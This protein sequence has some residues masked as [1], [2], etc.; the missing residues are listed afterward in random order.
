MPCCK[1]NPADAYKGHG[2]IS[3][4]DRKCRDVLCLLLF[5]AFSLGGLIIGAIGLKYG[6]PA[7]MLYGTDYEGNVCGMGAMK[8]RRYTAYP[9]GNFDFIMNAGKSP[10]DYSFY[11]ICV[12]S[13]PGDV[14]PVCNNMYYSKL[15]NPV[16]AAAIKVSVRK[17]VRRG[18]GQPGVVTCSVLL[19]VLPNDRHHPSLSLPSHFTSTSSPH[20]SPLVPRRPAFCLPAAATQPATPT[21]T[22]AGSMGWPP[23]LSS[24]AACRS[25]T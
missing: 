10:L 2:F 3:S 20:L 13:C 25:T 18:R 6:E 4:P 22:T 5:T 24:S 7:R 1:R 21:A 9:R 15:A 11:G 16:D 14:T 12:A 17:G 19:S 23:P 8:D